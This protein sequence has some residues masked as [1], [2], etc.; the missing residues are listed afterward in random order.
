[1][2]NNSSSVEFVARIA[3]ITS[4]T[5]LSI[6]SML[7]ALPAIGESL[8]VDNS[9]NLPLVITL[10]IFGMFFGELVFGPLSD[11]LG[12]KKAM[13]IGVLIYC[14]G[15][16]VA[17]V[18]TSL[19]SLLLGRMIQG[20]GVSGPKIISRAMIRDRFEGP[21]MARV[22]SFIMTVFICIPMVAP[23]LGQFI[24]KVS[25]WRSIF[26]VFLVMAVGS[27]GWI[28]IRQ[29][30]TL[31]AADRIPIRM[32][33]LTRTASRILSHPSVLCYSVTAGLVF[34]VFLLY[35]STSQIMFEQIYDKGESFPAYFALLASGFGL[36]A[37]LNSRLVMNYGMYRLCFGGLAGLTC[38]GV[39]SLVTGQDGSHSFTVFMAG[40]YF[41]MFCVGV[42]FSNLSAM[43]MQP[44]GKVAGLGASLVSAV[45]S[46]LAVVISVSVGRFYDNT[47]YPL[48][49]SIVLCGTSSLCLIIVAQKV[50]AEAVAS[51]A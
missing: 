28:L 4:L 29:P 40:C 15:T 10:F 24:V 11:S 38:L 37:I 13:T 26:F 25:G 20:F 2:E 21:R 23:A 12:R 22:F 17:M 42:L 44:L 5:A 34:G 43:A 33:N 47:L 50:K 27:T 39:F 19:E 6:D 46:I 30:E 3:L 8:Q 32:R 7:P 18:A 16:V 41:F 48:S 51:S 49:L 45:S 9:N 14:C 1:M 35:L 31:P 36:A